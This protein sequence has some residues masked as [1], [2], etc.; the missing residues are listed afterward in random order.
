MNNKLFFL[1]KKYKINGNGLKSN[2]FK[3]LLEASY[4]GNEE[5]EG[6]VLDKSISSNTSKVY[7]HPS[8]HVVVTHQGTT[9]AIDWGNNA[10]FA[11]TGDL[12]YK[13]TPRYKEALQVQQQAEKKYGAKNITTIGHSQGGYQA[14]LLGAITKEIITL[15]KAT[16]PQEWIY[17]S[18][19]KS[20]QYDVRA[21]GNLVS[22]FR[23]PFQRKKD[24]HI[25][26]NNDP[27]SQHSTN[28]LDNNK[29]D[30][31]YGNKKNYVY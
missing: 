8:G 9:T 26:S 23:I 6:F 16:R 18:S 4:S 28:I 20:N 1:Q 13:M 7:I 31:I 25:N 15:N 5:V 19:K 27:L 17:G 21:R 3:R 14:Q 12:G 22:F 2:T 24:E 11:A 30:I 29:N 10:V